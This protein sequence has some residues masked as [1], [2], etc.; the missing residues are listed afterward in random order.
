MFEFNG[1]EFRFEVEDYNDL[2][3][4]AKA[5]EELGQTEKTLMEQQKGGSDPE[6]IKGFCQ[7]I[8]RFFDTV[9]GEGSA[10]EMFGGK[11]NLGV[12]EEVYVQFLEYVN[13]QAQEAAKARVERR[14]RLG[15]YLPNRKSNIV[16]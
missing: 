14:E 3:N 1:K 16:S 11:L 10:E 8:F 4:Y 13:A 9:L 5:L 6:F 12:C 7:M 2:S 15:K